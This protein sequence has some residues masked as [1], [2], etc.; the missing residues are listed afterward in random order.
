MTIPVDPTAAEGER[1]EWSKLDR[2]T[3]RERLLTV[4]TEVFAQRGLDAPMSEVAEAAGAGV[5]SI[6]RAFPSKRDLLVAIVVRRMGQLEAIWDEA[7]RRPGDRWT[8]LTDLLRRLV[9]AQRT[10]STML[11]ARMAVADDP[12]A[13]AAV[14]RMARAQERLLAAA[15]QEG[16]LRPDATTLDMRLLFAATRAARNVEPEQWPRMLELMLAAL[17]TRSR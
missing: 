9:E 10:D 14:A 1:T 11:E 13:A 7:Y 17:D 6:Y 3:K 16:R 8:A 2:Q 15:R 12:E 5:A 4:A